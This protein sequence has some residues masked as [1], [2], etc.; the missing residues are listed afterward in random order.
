MQ[1]GVGI[2]AVPDP[3][4]R[5]DYS[6]DGSA[7]FVSEIPK[8]MGK[9]GEFKTRVRWTRLGRIPKSRVLRFKM[10][11]PVALNVYALYAN[12]EVTSSG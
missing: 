1:T 7:N 2:P 3:Q 12:L 4:I 6:D 8:P 5:M 11:D 9:V 10:S